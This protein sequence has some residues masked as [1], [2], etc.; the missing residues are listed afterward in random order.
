MTN[1]EIWAILPVRKPLERDHR[2][3]VHIKE[4]VAKAYD[5]MATK[6]QP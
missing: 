4:G 5:S 3:N 6:Q 1:L 2:E